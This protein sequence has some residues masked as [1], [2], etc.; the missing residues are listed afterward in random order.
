MGADDYLTKDISL[1]HLAARIG[2]LFRRMEALEQPADANALI[3]RGQLTL[4][5]QRMQVL[6]QH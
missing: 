5:T 6:W 4:D 3:I 1:A 2:A